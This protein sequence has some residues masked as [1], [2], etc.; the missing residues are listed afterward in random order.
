MC[1]LT[2][3]PL[4]EN[5]FVLTSS[6]D[7]HFSRKPSSDPK[8]SKI[9]GRNVVFPVDGEAGGTWIAASESG[10]LV[11]LLNGAFGK[12]KHEPPYRK[13]RGLIVL[14]SFNYN[15]F[16]DF[17]DSFGLEGIEPFTLVAVEAKKREIVD[18]RW[19]GNKKYSK[20][21]DVKH[22]HIWSSATLYSAEVQL[23]RENWFNQW[24]SVN[25]MEKASAKNFHLKGG[26]GTTESNFLM[27]R[28]NGV[29]TVSITQV[30]YDG[31][32]FFME[33]ER[34]GTNQIG[35]AGLAVNP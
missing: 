33:H 6:R 17:I 14:E 21:M 32:D 35:T 30:V 5:Q 13:S 15:N 22:K 4:I 31:M 25:P 2:Y 29:Q 1:T 16:N 10:R 9:N 18:L 12:H 34:L 23:E 7:E 19:D 24:F 27:K 28:P 3:I 26:K 8:I 11:C 20:S